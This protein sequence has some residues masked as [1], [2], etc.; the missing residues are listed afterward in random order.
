MPV[1][2]VGSVFTNAYLQAVRQA[3]QEQQLASAAAAAVTQLDPAQ[4][5]VSN[6]GTLGDEKTNATNS[7]NAIR[8]AA[9][10]H[11]GRVVDEEA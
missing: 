7:A 4:V 9:A 3:P 11:L 6:Q 2:S 8:P 5:G 10:P 1:E